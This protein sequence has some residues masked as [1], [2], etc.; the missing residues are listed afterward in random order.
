MLTIT[1]QGIES[2]K[3]EVPDENKVNTNG[4]EEFLEYGGKQDIICIS[5]VMHKFH[6]Q[7]PEVSSAEATDVEESKEP[8]RQFSFP[9]SIELPGWLP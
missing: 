3:W 2:T 6:S 8:E 4:N 1:F 7:V 9:F 5:R